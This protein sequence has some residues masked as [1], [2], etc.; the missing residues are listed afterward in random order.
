MKSSN[1]KSKHTFLKILIIIVAIL[2]IIGGIG[3]IGVHSIEAH[4]VLAVPVFQGREL[5]I[6]VAP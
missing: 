6:L 2:A 5:S 1:K 3:I 4:G